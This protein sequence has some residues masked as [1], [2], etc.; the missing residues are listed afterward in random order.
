MDT[1][2]DVHRD[3][4]APAKRISI[5]TDADY[6]HGV[7]AYGRDGRIDIDT[8]RSAHSFQLPKIRTSPISL[9]STLR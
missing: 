5:G 7:P 8:I 4:G 9:P 2:V 3:G 1:R 6:T